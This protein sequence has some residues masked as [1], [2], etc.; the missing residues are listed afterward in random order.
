MMRKRKNEE[1]SVRKSFLLYQKFAYL[2]DKVTLNVYQSSFDDS[3]NTPGSFIT[4]I[5]LP[6]SPSDR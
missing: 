3:I 2:T 6:S 4:F 1:D 5:L